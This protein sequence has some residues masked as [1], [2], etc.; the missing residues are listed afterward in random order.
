MLLEAAHLGRGT[1][2]SRAATGRA[3]TR[4][5]SRG[6]ARRGRP[7]GTRFWACSRDGAARVGDQRRRRSA[8]RRRR[9]RHRRPLAL[10]LPAAAARG[11]APLAPEPLLDDR[12]C[13]CAA[14]SLR[15]RARVSQA[16][17]QAA[18]RAQRWARSRATRRRAG[19]ARDL[20][21]L[22]RRAGRA[23]R[24]RDLGLR[25]LLARRCA[26]A[27]SI[28]SLRRRPLIRLRPITRGPR[29][30]AGS[31]PPPCPC[32][33]PASPRS[34]SLRPRAWRGRAA[35]TRSSGFGAAGAGSRV[36][37]AGSGRSRG[38][39]RGRRAGRGSRPSA[40]RR[41]RSRR[42]PISTGR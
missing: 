32:A 17:G 1:R 15:H 34:P 20:V 26:G 36:D 38:R 16:F 42:P 3:A 35:P 6:R 30:S 9:A 28:T 25:E 24:S 2:G 14:R 4:G 31:A 22:A 5:C 40:R 11:R 18:R 39:A 13:P 8:G 23:S 19:R 27:V 7:S 29:R 37:D 12:A 41:R 21:R 10:P 33:A